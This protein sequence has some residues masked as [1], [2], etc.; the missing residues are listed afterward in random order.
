MLNAYKNPIIFRYYEELNTSFQSPFYELRPAIANNPIIVRPTDE[1]VF[2]LL[3]E[4]NKLLILQEDERITFEA[5]TYCDLT[6][7]DISLRLEITIE[8]THFRVH[9]RRVQSIF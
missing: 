3:H 9:F 8:F 2:D 5:D 4:G 1:E 7:M 6:F